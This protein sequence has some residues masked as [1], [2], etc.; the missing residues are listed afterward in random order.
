[1]ICIK[2]VAL[3]LLLENGIIISSVWGE[4]GIEIVGERGRKH[5]KSI[6]VQGWPCAHCIIS[7]LYRDVCILFIIDLVLC[8]HGTLIRWDSWVNVW[9]L[10]FVFL[11]CIFVWYFENFWNLSYLISRMFL[12]NIIIIIIIIVIII[13]QIMII[14]TRSHNCN[15]F[16]FCIYF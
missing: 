12:E 2:A 6:S 7:F 16:C 5:M 4:R 10:T 8:E 9:S 13:I 11:Y 3:V 15:A 1:M 14:M